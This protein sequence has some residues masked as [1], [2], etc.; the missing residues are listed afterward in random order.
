[1]S[2]SR[3]RR[4]GGSVM[5]SRSLL[6]ILVWAAFAAP[7]LKA[8]SSMAGIN[9]YSAPQRTGVSTNVRIAGFPQG[10]TLLPSP[11]LSTPAN[12]A[13]ARNNAW[14]AYNA[15]LRQI[16]TASNP[17]RLAAP[18]NLLDKNRFIEKPQSHRYNFQFSDNEIRSV[19]GALKRLGL[20]S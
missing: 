2:F 8:Q 18:E 6:F 15:G 16:P 11:L 14:T 19:Q 9:V 4:S 12:D 5:R 17:N 7:A 1:M 13:W 3:R 10:P 20:Y